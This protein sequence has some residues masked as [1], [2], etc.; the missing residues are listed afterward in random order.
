MPSPPDPEIN[1]NK[2]SIYMN[3]SLERLPELLIVVRAK[4]NFLPVR[5][6]LPRSPPSFPGPSRSFCPTHASI[7]AFCPYLFLLFSEPQ[8]LSWLGCCP[9]APLAWFCHHLL[10][11]A[12]PECPA[13]VGPDPASAPPNPIALF[14]FLHSK[15]L[16]WNCL[17]FFVNFVSK[18]FVLL[19]SDT[20]F[21][22]EK[23][24]E[25]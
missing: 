15:C 2:P 19:G 1:L 13:Q 10:Q 9:L 6:L 16:C 17:Y 20:E 4:S 14:C 11:E 21:S 23:H 25:K 7:S 5:C 18:F 8:G 24:S 22:G 3:H 12:L